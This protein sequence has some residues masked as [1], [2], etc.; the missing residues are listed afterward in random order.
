MF[1]KKDALKLWDTEMGNKDYAYDFS[2]R[3][4]KKTDYLEKNQVGWDITYMHPLEQ[5]GPA[6]IGNIIIAHHMTIEEKGQNYPTFRIV[7][8]DY[9]VRYDK[10]NDFYYIELV[11]SEDDDDSDSYFI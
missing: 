9:I 10:T 1:D 5:G 11:I 6:H 2:G 3:K 4:I 8:K 7:D